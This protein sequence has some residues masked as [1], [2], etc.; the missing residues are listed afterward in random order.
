MV[1]REMMIITDDLGKDC[2][3]GGAGADTFR[4]ISGDNQQDRIHDFELNV[5]LIDIRA[6]GATSV[7]ELTFTEL[8]DGSGNPLGDLIIDYGDESLRL[9]GFAASDITNFDGTQFVFA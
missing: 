6:W 5:D 2:L 8:S 4:F 3:W 1:G 7:S 9:D